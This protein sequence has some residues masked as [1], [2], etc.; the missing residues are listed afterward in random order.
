MAK[1]RVNRY[2]KVA[3]ATASQDRNRLSKT[4]HYVLR[5]DRVIEGET[6]VG[7]PYNVAEFT[8]MHDY[9]DM[10]PFVDPETKATSTPHIPGE[11]GSRYFDATQNTFAANWKGFMEG[12]G[13]IDDEALEAH[14]AENDMS[15]EDAWIE[16]CET[17][18]S[19]EQPLAGQLVEVTIRMTRVKAARE[20]SEADLV[21][22]D[23]WTKVTYK[24]QMTYEE[25]AR[26]G[27]E[28]T[29]ARLV[30]DLAERIEAEAA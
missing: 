26:I 19:E 14:A 5:V 12:A 13:G 22:R 15:V 9:G 25:L 8:V 4:G 17:V 16:A 20:K 24:R 6:D 23:F 30:P 27:D 29:V 11:T 10:E 21:R 2:S 3:E 18:C 28:A 7:A 1:K